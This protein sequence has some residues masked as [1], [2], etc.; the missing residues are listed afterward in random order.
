MAPLRWLVVAVLAAGCPTPQP[1]VCGPQTCAGCCDETGACQL[2]NEA[3]ACGAS[4][5]FC[6]ACAS[7]QTCSA[8]Q[9]ETNDVDGGSATTPECEVP[10]TVDFGLIALNDTATR[11]LTFENTTSQ[12]QTAVIT[13]TSA[14]G[15][16]VSP[17]GTVSVAAGATQRIDVGFTATQL[18]GAF[19][20]L[21]VQRGPKCA[22]VNVRLTAE[23][24]QSVLVVTPATVDF[25][26]ASLLSTVT[27][28]VVFQNLGAAPIQVFNLATTARFSV[29][30]GGSAFTVPGTSSSTLTLAF[31]PSVLGA[32]TG[33]LTFE[34]DAVGQAAL[35]VPLQGIGGGPAIG[36]DD[37][38]TLPPTAVFSTQSAQLTVTN[39][40]TGTNPAGNLRFR[41]PAF[42]LVALGSAELSD[43]LVEIAPT[44]D[45]VNGVAVNARTSLIVS[46][47]PSTPGTKTAEL[48]LHTNDTATPDRV[49][50]LTA[51][52]VAT[53]AC[54]Y[55]VSPA[56]PVDF[57]LV[58]PGFTVD[59]P[60]TVTNTGSIDCTVLNAAPT[61]TGS[62][63]SVEG[64]VTTT[65]A[66][67]ASM[68]FRARYTPPPAASTSATTLRGAV[69]IHTSSSVTPNT[70]VELTATTGAN[71]VLAVADVDFGGAP[72]GCRSAPRSVRVVNV[73]PTSV[74]LSSASVNSASGAFTVVSGSG[75]S[76]AGTSVHDFSV[77]FQPAALGADEALLSFTSLQ[78]GSTIRHV[79]P[80]RGA[81][82]N[83]VSD[84]FVVPLRPKLDLL[85]VVDDSCSMA[86]RHAEL[87]AFAPTLMATASAT[88][89]DLRVG[90]IT[91]D[92]TNPSRG[93][94]R[95]TAVGSAVVSTSQ[96]NAGPLLAELF[97]AGT[98]GGTESCLEPTNLALRD[99]AV[100]SLTENGVIVR[101]ASPLGVVCVTDA[102]DKTPNPV[103]YE[104]AR[105]SLSRSA[106]SGLSYSVIGPFLP[107]PPA[108]CTYD[109]VNTSV[110]ADAIARFPGQQEE[111][112]TSNWPAMMTRVLQRLGDLPRREFTLSRSVDA[113]GPG[114]T[115]TVNG[116]AVPEVVNGTTVWSFDAING[117]LTFEA[118]NAP[119][120]GNSVVIS[121]A[122]LCF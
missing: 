12:T 2:G 41:T 8:Q 116:Q 104:L 27:R 28:D 52:A 83:T 112:C 71:C 33:T 94:L 122:T 20:M 86:P 54:T 66:P 31:S 11:Q 68:T 95:R 67:S 73:C 34:T 85:F 3:T 21:S 17:V 47:S 53:S 1:G 107:S 81:G 44:Y 61:T 75:A 38:L 105:L 30:G 4:G 35:S 5:A 63:F 13:W 60:V 69:R 6:S 115:V 50:T 80:L 106:R 96:P 103:A 90:V 102:A 113:A 108:G 19:A 16:T 99:D 70:E 58:R 42:T 111:I 51:T 78:A 59:W 100:S 32:R 39:V 114:V 119:A 101:E 56:S 24:V 92:L 40:G 87:A 98:A 93:R 89:L 7:D 76:V 46:F 48:H 22:A 77:Q 29:V 62:F 23:V 55:S 65:L 117:R 43:F 49:V 118:L 10:R 120:A 110:H 109:G 36:V 64:F 74:V 97:D 91:T 25:G 88:R 26:Y 14:A 121:Y 57:G 45:E 84:T 18:G 15:Y 79:V 37:T 72:V 9:C 82:V